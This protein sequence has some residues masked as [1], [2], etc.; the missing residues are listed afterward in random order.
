DFDLNDNSRLQ[1]GNTGKFVDS[2]FAGN[3]SILGDVTANG[4]A[5]LDLQSGGTGGL[6]S[7]P[8]VNTISGDLALSSGSIYNININQQV[9]TG[10]KVGGDADLNNA[11]VHLDNLDANGWFNFGREYN[12]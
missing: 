6:H 4:Q 12:I 9:A 5:T 11:T 2:T 8:M 1:M 10:A 3:N 7:A